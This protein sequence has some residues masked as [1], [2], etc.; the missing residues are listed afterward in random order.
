MKKLIFDVT[1]HDDTNTAKTVAL[2]FDNFTDKIEN[3]FYI[4]ESPIAS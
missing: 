3:K 4:D 1:Y 2:E